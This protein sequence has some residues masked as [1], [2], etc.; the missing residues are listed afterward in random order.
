MSPKT[1]EASHI[2]GRARNGNPQAVPPQPALTEREK[3]LL[4][5]LRSDGAFDIISNADAAKILNLIYW[6]D[7]GR[8]RTKAAPKKLFNRIRSNKVMIF[9]S[10][11]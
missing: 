3:R 5:L 8:C 7:N 11:N 4:L 9:F 6:P 1:G 2:K 10:E